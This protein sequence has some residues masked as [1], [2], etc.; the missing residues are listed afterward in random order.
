MSV[1]RIEIRQKLVI[2]MRVGLAGGEV[3]GSQRD[4]L[5]AFAGH[6]RRANSWLRN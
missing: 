2:V 1:D 6:V 5:R 3:L 4:S